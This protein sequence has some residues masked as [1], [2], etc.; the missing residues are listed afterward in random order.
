MN[1]YLTL[2][3]FKNVDANTSSTRFVIKEGKIY[4]GPVWDY[5]LSSGNC[6][7]DYYL[8]YNNALTTGNSY[9]GL[10]A[11]NVPWFKALFEYEEFKTATYDRYLEIQD[12]IVNLYRDNE[13]GK[14]KLDT[15]LEA[16]GDSIYRNH[17]EAGWTVD[18]VYNPNLQLERTPDKTYEENLMFYREW[19]EQRNAWLLNMWGLVDTDIE[20][21]TDVPKIIITTTEEIGKDD[22]VDATI[23]IID[24]EGGSYEMILDEASKIKIRGNSTSGSAKKPYN[25]KFSSKTDVLG[26]GKNKKW[27]ILAN[28]F[29]KTLIR[30]MTVFDFANVA[31]VPYTP[32]YRVVDVY[33]NGVFGGCYIITDSIEVGPTRVDIDTD[34]NEFLLELDYNTPDEDCQY[35]NSSRYDIK[36]AINEPE[37]EDLT[38]DQ[39]AYVQDLITKAENALA[40]NNYN[41]ISQY[42]DIDSMV[43]FYI[44]LEFFKNVDAAQSST[45]FHI[46][47]GKI[48]GGPVWDYDLSSGNCNDDYYYDYN[49]YTTNDISSNTSYQGIWVTL[50]PW[51]SRLMSNSTFKN[52]VYNRYLELQD[53]IVNLYAD[54][55]LGQN[56]IDY[57]LETYA[58]SITRNQNE[59]GWVVD[60]VYNPLFQ[61]ERD[62][63]PTYVE[64]V[65]FFR[66]W[67]QKRNEWLLSNWGLNSN[68][69]VRGENYSKLNGYMV[70]GVKV[71]TTAAQLLSDYNGATLMYN[72]SALTGNA[73]VRNG[74]YLVSS[75]G[76]KKYAITL[77]GDVYADGKINVMDYIM[78]KRAVIGTV[79]L[80]EAAKSAADIRENGR[81][82]AIDYLLIK[83]HVL[84]SYT[85]G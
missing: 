51:F 9:E 45:R 80:D 13:L 68:I 56:R 76:A 59:A 29:D 18:K 5:D 54:N 17:N 78:V 55:V 21:P 12:I 37:L 46:K 36:F 71:G 11:I 81:L 61:G 60:Q 50:V 16:Y 77:K 49:N 73:L 39:F 34:N 48:Y 41:Q 66:Y 6:N 28:S 23:K 57:Y 47:D 26:M 82:E 35:F 58:G 27:S 85:I 40:T 33:V 62:P 3:Y 30:N 14:N 8:E 64:N 20:A 32:D 63:D 74:A 1:F 25:I 2:E 24:E 75:N 22:Y 43:N 38:A 7:F 72:G 4:G 65:E 69:T 44:T 42:F 83:R 53:Q 15:Y 70:E 31:G 67:L 84:G 19:L 10:W 79:V 52:A